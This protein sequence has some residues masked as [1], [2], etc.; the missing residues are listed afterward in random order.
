M[1]TSLVRSMFRIKSPDALLYEASGADT[2][3]PHLRRSM[4]VVALTLFSV[5]SIIGT[6]IFIVLG[7]A[8]PK[9][10]PA[11]VVAF[12]LAAVACMFSALSYAE[13]A[14]TIPVSGSSYSYAYATLGEFIAWVVGWC[15]MLEYGL[16]V[17]AV[18]VG[19][20][21]Y[22]NAFL[23]DAIDVRLP[24]AIIAPPGG[25]G[26]VNLS[27]VLV[28]VLCSAFL[29]RGTSE[30]AKLNSAMVLLKIAIL[31]FFCVVA[32][33]AFTPGN[34][35]PFAPL[36]VAGI[37]AAAGKVFFSFIGF[38]GVSTAGEEAKNATRD[39]PIAI[40]ASLVIVAT[41]YVLVAI[42]AIGAQ[43]WQSFAGS[44]EEAVLA[45]IAGRVTGSSWAP[46]IIALGAVVSIFSVVLVTM[47][48]HTRI[49]FAMGRD[50]LLP[51][52][53]TKVSPRTQTPVWNTVIVTVIVAFLAAFVSLDELS[54]ATS[55]GTLVAF[56]VV[57]IGVIVL[58]RTRPDLP[59]KFKVPWGPVLPVMG[60]LLN[61]YLLTS[62][63]HVTWI[64]FGS[65]MVLGLGIYFGYGRRR[66]KLN[67]HAE[68]IGPHGAKD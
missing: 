30:S 50:G 27:A 8:V 26:V 28:I 35:T 9:A 21:Q 64:A 46:I 16:A 13:L 53:F 32:F 68:E 57:N 4:G 56:I 10:G 63:G 24:D 3:S 1:S 19:W 23:V 5:G 36:G 40:I 43:P 55:I 6:G 61:L 20:G 12:V 37:G 54:D 60:I 2:E 51:R 45:Q 67:S 25:G 7:T 47:Y 18:A 66:S 33:T 49:L 59:R 52:V 48:G 38:D 29:I 39:L 15:L 17:S 41:V 44:G 11:I 58:R 14:S 34:F 65:W 42:A 22:L 31:V 62:L